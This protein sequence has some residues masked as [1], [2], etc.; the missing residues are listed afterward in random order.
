MKTRYRALTAGLML[1]A[2][3]VSGVGWGTAA[4]AADSPSGFSYGTDSWP[5][6]GTGSTLGVLGSA[7]YGPLDGQIVLHYTDGSTQTA[8]LGLSDWSLNAGASTPS[9]GNAIVATMPYRDVSTGKDATA[10]YLFSEQIPLAAGKTLASVTLPGPA[11][12]GA[13]DVFALTV[14]TPAS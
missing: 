11:A 10:S 5:V 6:S 1:A 14:G 13:E 9:Y 12:K 2:A 4:R 8:S 3:T 7:Y